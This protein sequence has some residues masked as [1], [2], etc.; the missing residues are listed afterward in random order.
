MSSGD[1]ST[2]E[3]DFNPI[4]KST[5]IDTSSQMSE[6]QGDVTAT[7]EEPGSVSISDRKLCNKTVSK[8]AKFRRIERENDTEDSVSEVKSKLAQLLAV[9]GN[10][11]E[12]SKK[13]EERK[14]ETADKNT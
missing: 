14:T 5:Q 11:M 2:D 9:A 1:D 6:I 3:D 13:P 4:F 8:L 10:L 7:L 12:N